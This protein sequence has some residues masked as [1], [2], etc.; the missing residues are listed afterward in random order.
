MAIVKRG[1]KGIYHTNFTAPNGKRIRVSTQTSDK[2]AAQEFHDRL[3]AQYWRESKL[4][5]KPAKSWQET[6]CRHIAEL[7]N[8]D[9]SFK[10][11]HLRIL[12]EYLKNKMLN[13]IDEALISEIK[14]NRLQQKDKRYK[15]GDAPTVSRTTVNHTLVVLK[16]VLNAAK[17][18]GWIDRVPTI[19]KLA[20]NKE[21]IERIVWLTHEEA[22]RLINE[23]PI[24][25]ERMV[26]FSLLTGL[27]ESN[28][29]GLKWEWVNKENKLAWI[30]PG[31]S[32]NEKA[33][34]VP[35]NGEAIQLLE[36]LQGDHPVYVFTYRGNPVK[37][38]NTVA[39]RK[40]LDRA[41]IRPYFVVGKKKLSSRKQHYPTK[42]LHE[43]SQPTFREHDLRHTWASWHVQAGTP[44]AVLQ[45]LGGWS[46]YQMVLRYAHLSPNH[47]AQFADS[48]SIKKKT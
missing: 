35:L 38:I 40:A 25:L 10:L 28:V 34:Q 15:Y 41:G 36:E 48:I 42:P 47:V 37:S 11:E 4:G 21:D 9:N 14:I 44:L 1:K 7:P 5:D 43:Y 22:D 39:W 2:V 16:A 32:K 20:V 45:Q 3:K 23:L 18:W 24:H 31:S 19:E 12:D 30:P 46:S 27:R 6:V 13:E 29:Y 26:R 17:K 8:K 33:I